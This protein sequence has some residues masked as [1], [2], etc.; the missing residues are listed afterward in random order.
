[1]GKFLDDPYPVIPR[2][3]YGRRCRCGNRQE[4]CRSVVLNFL[5]NKEHWY[6][7]SSNYF[8]LDSSIL[9]LPQSASLQ[10]QWNTL[11]TGV[12]VMENLLW[13]RFYVDK[14]TLSGLYTY[15][16][17]KTRDTLNCFVVTL[18]WGHQKKTGLRFRRSVTTW[19]V[20]VRTV[21]W[22]TLMSRQE[23]RFG[24]IGDTETGPTRELVF[25]EKRYVCVYLFGVK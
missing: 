7:S 22:Y 14:C 5:Q 8:T 20:Y 13:N 19:R 17:G 21:G 16:N 24:K 10:R 25:K 9:T 23:R 15:K 18:D 6:L 2:R 12:G 1:M 11:S 4:W 3:N